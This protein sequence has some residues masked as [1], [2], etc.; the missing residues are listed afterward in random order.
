MIW[1]QF[2]CCRQIL[3]VF[4]E[5][6]GL[7]LDTPRESLLFHHKYT[8]VWKTKMP[9]SW[10]QAFCYFACLP[11]REHINKC[12]APL[13]LCDKPP[14]TS[15]ACTKMYLAANGQ[16]SR[17]IL[18]DCRRRMSRRYLLKSV[19]NTKIRK[20]HQ[21]YDKLLLWFMWAGSICFLLLVKILT[22]SFT[23]RN[24]YYY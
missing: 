24:V 18:L 15:R 8:C 1:W 9:P 5:S 19:K 12:D 20:I 11:R 2:L 13:F 16:S 17:S 7:L 10:Q 3:L 14:S 22:C 4:L 21:M 23:M 6:R